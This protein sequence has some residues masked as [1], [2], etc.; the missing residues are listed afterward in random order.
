MDQEL[1]KVAQEQG[2]LAWGRDSRKQTGKGEKVRK[3]ASGTSAPP[4]VCEGNTYLLHGPLAA[5]GRLWAALSPEG[6]WRALAAS[7]EARW[8]PTWSGIGSLHSRQRSGPPQSWSLEPLPSFSVARP[9]WDSRKET[10]SGFFSSLPPQF[11]RRPR[12]LTSPHSWGGSRGPPSLI[13]RS[14]LSRAPSC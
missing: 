9:V 5:P 13:L 1:G 4:G 7:G 11:W 14:F 6:L 12:P 10:F 3:V 8:A 2:P